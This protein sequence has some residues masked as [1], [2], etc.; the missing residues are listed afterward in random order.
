MNHDKAQR[1]D[2]YKGYSYPAIDIF[3]D[4]IVK[5]K[6]LLMCLVNHLFK[7]YRNLGNISI[8]QRDQKIVTYL[9]QWWSKPLIQLTQK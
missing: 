6:F 7:P 9:L 8:F 1:L 3:P 2:H 4:E 5:V